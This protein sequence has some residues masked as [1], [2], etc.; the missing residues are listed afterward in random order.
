MGY[1]TQEEKIE[2]IDR[3]SFDRQNFVP[4]ILME[5]ID[6]QIFDRKF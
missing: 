2:N 4:Q 5:N 6:R 3:Q 1:Q